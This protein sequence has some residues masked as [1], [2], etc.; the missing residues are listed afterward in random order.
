MLAVVEMLGIDVDKLSRLL[1][2]TG[3]ML[4]CKIDAD[5]CSRGELL[6][7]VNAKALLLGI[8]C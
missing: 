2:I 3:C 1:D 6:P 5:N 7:C 8:V 4:L